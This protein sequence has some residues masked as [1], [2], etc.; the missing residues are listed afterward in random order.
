MTNVPETRQAFIASD[1]TGLTAA[2]MAQ[3]LLAQFPHVPFR[4]ETFTFVDT[5]SKARDVVERCREA[6]VRDGVAP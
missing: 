2:A 5:A 1:R 6:T 4:T 3:S